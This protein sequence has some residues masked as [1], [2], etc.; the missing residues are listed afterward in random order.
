M[1]VG[2]RL[3]YGRAAIA[4]RSTE[5]QRADPLCLHAIHKLTVEQYL[6]LY[7]SLYGLR[8]AIARVTNPYGPGQP[9]GR[10]AY[11]VV[12]RL[13]HLALAGEALPDLRRRPPAPRLH[14]RRRCRVRRSCAWR[15]SP[16]SDGRV[17]N[18]GTGVGTRI[19]DMARAIIELAGGGRVEHVAVAARWPNRS[20][21]AISSPTSSRIRARA[22]LGARSCRSRDGLR[23][24]VAFYRAH[25]AS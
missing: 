12:N 19:V 20:R 23:R 5:D 24:T 1:F 16:S 2:S 13:I 17:Y 9:R 4:S 11:G 7:G 22:R 8:F 21:P 14:L 18:V 6:R 10:T 3:A 25:V 15:A